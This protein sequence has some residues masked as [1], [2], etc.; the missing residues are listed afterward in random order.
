MKTVFVDL[1]SLDRDD[2]DLS[3]IERQ[4]SELVSY[5]VT[6]PDQ[7]S[8]RLADAQVVITNKTVLDAGLLSML[9]QLKLICIAATGSDNVDLDAARQ[10]GIVVSNCQGYGTGSVVQHTFGLMLALATRLQ[11]YSAAVGRGDWGRSE[12]FCLLDYPIMELQGKTL[13]I[14]GFGE[15]GQ[16]VGRIAEAFGMRVLVAARP[17]T[18][19]AAGRLALAELLP[20]VDILSLHCPLTEQSRNLI[21]APALALM[22]SSALLVN[23]ARGG[24]VDEAALADALRAGRLGGA[25]VDVLAVEP[26]VD[27]N[28]LLAD[29][30]P[31]LIVTPHSAWGSVEAR[32]RIVGQIADNIAAFERGQPQRQV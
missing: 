8:H 28:P 25:G 22:K 17:G 30:I 11:D 7:L 21:D 27:G 4:A 14:V 26:P 18:E 5:G 13:G 2:L 9:P 20:Q 3:V 19:P 6:R 12:Q 10:R 31:N 23:A 16:A 32:Q 29:D 1:A 24:I 15:L